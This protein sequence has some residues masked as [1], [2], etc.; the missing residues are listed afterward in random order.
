MNILSKLY[1]TVASAAVLSLSMSAGSASAANLDWTLN[2][3]AFSD[4]GTATGSFKYDA[5]TSTYRAFSISV[6]GGSVLTPFTYNNSNSFTQAGAFVDT[7]VRF[8]KNDFSRY[9]TLEFFN[10][11]TNAG[12]TVPLVKGNLGQA[13]FEC[14]Q[15]ICSSNTVTRNITTG[16][17]TARPIPVPGAVFGIIVAG[18]ALI[19]KQR[20]QVKDKQAIS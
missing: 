13:S 12:G 10:A 3:V 11:L 14:K 20:K 1:I 9:L 5:D 17:V 2:N 15:E 4:G 16:T 19:A 8:E 7:D 6:Q 18:G